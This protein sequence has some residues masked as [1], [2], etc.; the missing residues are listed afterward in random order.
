MILPLKGCLATS[1]G[2]F[3]CYWNLVSR[4]QGCRLI[5]CNA[6]DGPYDTKNRLA[7]NVNSVKC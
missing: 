4:G 3:G 1:G 5:S 2:I 6:W 7:P